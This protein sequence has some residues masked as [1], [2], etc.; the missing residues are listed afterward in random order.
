MDQNKAIKYINTVTKHWALRDFQKSV[1]LYT[2]RPLIP[3]SLFK[4]RSFDKFSFKMIRNGYLYM[5]TAD[6]LDDP[7]EIPL[8]KSNVLS[9]IAPADFS[10][11]FISK[12][13]E[14]ALM[15]AHE[16]NTVKLD[17]L[18]NLLMNGKGADQKLLHQFV[19]ESCQC[20]GTPLR[21]GL[22]IK[23]VLSS[24]KSFLSSKGFNNAIKS[25][26]G[27]FN[28][29]ATSR[30]CSLS[31][32]N[33]NQLMWSLY[34]DMYKGYCLEYSTNTERISPESL[35]PVI[36]DEKRN[37]NIAQVTLHTACKMLLWFL[38][39]F[40]IEMDISDLLRLILTKSTDWQN[41]R[42]W[43]M[44][45]TNE[46]KYV[47]NLELKNIYV[48]Y[49]ADKD[50]V[51]QLLDLQKEIPFGLYKTVIDK[52]NLKIEFEPIN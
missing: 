42:E 45:S 22:E 49:N 36:Y 9:A 2:I 27:L 19:E 51:E 15:S 47:N 14:L 30:I 6:E 26:E 20:T 29:F 44:F 38:G 28:T 40:E 25:C 50:N 23:R 17:D 16:S 52:E 41:Q 43:R 11:A 48:G 32:T 4:Y 33:S 37:I 35:F 10:K 39:D 24:P 12:M 3:H 31:E 18:Y 1:S 13:H 34:A 8:P 7:F 5:A 21:C 46:I